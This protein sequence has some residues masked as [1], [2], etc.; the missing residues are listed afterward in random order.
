MRAMRISKGTLHTWKQ[1][2]ILRWRLVLSGWV[3]PE[4]DVQ[5][6]IERISGPYTPP[7]HELRQVERERTSVRSATKL[8]APSHLGPQRFDGLR[9]R[10]CRS[11]HEV[12]GVVHS[13]MV[14]TLVAETVVGAPFV[15][16]LCG[17]RL[18]VGPY[19]AHQRSA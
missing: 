2:A 16:D 1:L 19:N 3:Q 14:V 7:P 6:G 10:T 12:P 13:G 17:G 11:V 18:D 4:D 9:V 5:D 8:V 15:R